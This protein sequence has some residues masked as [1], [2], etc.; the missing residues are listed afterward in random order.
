MNKHLTI[1]V[2]KIA[3]VASLGLMQFILAS[4]LSVAD[5]GIY[6]FVVSLNLI[7][8]AVTVWGLDKYSTKLV[9]ININD[10]QSTSHVFVKNLVKIII[11]NGVIVAPFYVLVLYFG[12][13]DSL[14]HLILLLSFSLL[15]VGSCTLM[16]ASLTKGVG[17]VIISEV[18]YN[19]LRPIV[20]TT[21]TII[22]FIQ[23]GKVTVE[24]VQSFMLVA[25]GIVTVALLYISIKRLSFSPRYEVNQSF[26]VRTLYKYGFPFLIMGLGQTY[27]SSV[28]ALMIGLMLDTSSVAIYALAS[29]LV[30]VVL[31]GL[32]AA[33]M[34]IMPK[35]A[36]LYKDGKLSEM[37]AMIKNNNYFIAIVT[38]PVIAMLFYFNEQIIFLINPNYSLSSEIVNILLIGQA[39]NILSGPVIIVCSMAGQQLVAARIMF[40]MCVAQTLLGYILI[41]RYGVKGAA[42]ANVIVNVLLNLLLL[43]VVHYKVKIDPSFVGLFR[44]AKAS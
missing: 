19:L 29:K 18:F 37:S 36:P 22:T 4:K 13:K 24:Q 28:D 12:L 5:Y 23:F 16:T 44:R 6:S 10:G 7:M 42:Y 20:V 2:V 32:V 1:L 3:S 27:L 43:A 38:I 33:N 8:V 14:S 41:Q 34:L 11:L 17:R 21:L 35:V 9:A 30:G 25:Y 31:M 26:S 40:V 39:V 15:L